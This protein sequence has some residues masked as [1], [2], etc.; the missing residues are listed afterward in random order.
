[1]GHDKPQLQGDLITANKLPALLEL[2]IAAARLGGAFLR[3][4]ANSPIAVEAE[5]KRDVKLAA[6]KGSEEIIIRVL[7]EGSSFPILSEEMGLSDSRAS[8]TGVHWLVDPLDGSL[9]YLKG[10]PL[11]CVSIGLWDGHKPLLGVIYDFHREELFRGIPGQSAWLN[12]K[13]IQVSVTQEVQKAILCTGFPVS[14]DYSSGAILQFVGQVRQYKKLRLLG[15][16]ALSLAYVAAGRADSYYERDIKIWDVGA[17]IALVR[18]A[19]GMT[20]QTASPTPFAVT[21]YAGN[22]L[23]PHIDMISS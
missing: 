8:L 17:G 11:C 10:I 1:M 15:S 9:N 2:A 23:L 12:D 14:T 21:V 18:A 4:T 6:D 20:V 7:R 5:L 13:L 3:K 19:G 22:R 16:A